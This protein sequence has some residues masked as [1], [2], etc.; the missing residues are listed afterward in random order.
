MAGTEEGGRRRFLSTLAA[1][2]L[3]GCQGTPWGPELPEF[4]D[5]PGTW[6][7]G[8]GSVPAGRWP[9][10]RH[11][12]GQSGAT[13]A[14]GPVPPLEPVWAVDVG[15]PVETP[16]A[17]D[18][19]VFV[20]TEEPGRSLL[21]LDAATGVELWAA[22]MRAIPSGAAA[23]VD[24]T[25][26]VQEVTTDTSCL[27]ARDAATGAIRW[28]ADIDHWRHD[29]IVGDGTV[30]V[31][32]I[33]G[34]L[35]LES[36]TGTRAWTF[37]AG[38]RQPVVSSVALAGEFAYVTAHNRGYGG[39]E[40]PEPSGAVYALEPAVGSV[41][42]SADLTQPKRVATAGDRVL[43]ADLETL[44]AF[45]RHTGD[46]LWRV[47]LRPPNREFLRL[48]APFAVAHGRVYYR[49]TPKGSGRGAAVAAVSLDDGTPEAHFDLRHPDSS[50]WSPVLAVAGDLLY[51]FTA[52]ERTWM[53][54]IDLSR[55][56]VV[57]RDAVAGRALFYEPSPTVADAMVFL[58]GR[59][60]LTALR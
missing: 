47:P 10:V 34:L 29:P 30:Y 31:P 41:A 7:S 12:A 5:G 32:T 26:Y 57:Q 55:G 17:A 16:V 21:A 4:R 8:P 45:D 56:S 42:W 25:H 49:T 11:D 35:A 37:T 2:V 53:D 1:S 39:P 33:G 58:A 15:S 18:D 24:G 59:D 19:R 40:G 54:V 9:M 38:E 14:A 50:S 48:T 36:A 22:E 46:R 6:Q 20:T 44:D 52:G 27:A 43:V 23:A 13:G 28:T 60:C 3:A 51:A